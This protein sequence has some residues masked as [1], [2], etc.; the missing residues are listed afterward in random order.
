MQCEILAKDIEVE[1]TTRELYLHLTARTPV[2]LHTTTADVANLMANTTM[3]RGACT[4]PFLQ[5]SNFDSTEGCKGSWLG[6]ITQNSAKRLAD[7]P[8]RFCAPVP[9]AEG[10]IQCCLPCPITDWVYSDG[11]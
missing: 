5:L 4:A 1:E 2:L 8:G 10:I 7:L 11:E 6:T 9:S 3:G